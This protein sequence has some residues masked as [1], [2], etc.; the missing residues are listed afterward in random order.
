M[1]NDKMIRFLKS[2]KIE[3]I[4]DF[5]LDFEMIGRNR[6]NKDQF[7]MIILKKTPWKFYLLE[8][9]IEALKNIDYKYTIQFSYLS[10]PSNDDLI[11]L[12]TDWYKSIY[13][14]TSPFEIEIQDNRIIASIREN[15]EEKSSLYKPIIDDFNKFLNF[16]GYEFVMN[17]IILPPLPNSGMSKKEIKQINKVAKTLANEEIKE[18]INSNSGQIYTKDTIEEINKNHQIDMDGTQNVLLENM[19][20]NFEDMKKERERIRLNKRGNYIPF[21]SIDLIDSNSGNVDFDGKIFSIDINDKGKNKRLTIG[22]N[23][24]FGGAIYV[25]MYENKQVND[26]FI[27]NLAKGANIRVRGVAYIDDFSKALTIKGHY[28]DLLPADVINHETSPIPRVELHLHSQMS[29]QDG[30]GSMHDYMELAQKLGHKAMA[31]TDHGVVQGFPEAYKEGKAHGIKVIYGCEFYMVD[32]QLSYV[33]NPTDI[34]LNKANYVVLDLETTGLSC[35]YNRMMEFGAVKVEKGIVTQR[36]DLLINPG[37]EIP[38]KISEITNITNEMLKDKPLAKDALKQIL[39]FIGDSIIVTH[40]ASFDYNFLNEELK[41]NGMEVI[42]NPVIDTLSLSRYLF[43]ENRR[44]SLGNL[45]RTMEVSYDEESAHRADYDAE[46][47]NEVWQPMLSL[48]TKEN[49]HLKHSDLANLK[50]P[51]ELL[52]HIMPV[53]IVALAKNKEGIKSLYKLVSIGH[54][55]YLAGLPKVPRFELEKNRENLIIGSAC[56]NGEVFRSARYDTEEEIKRKISFYDYIEIQPLENYSFLVN[57][58]ELSDSE[59]KLCV[60]DIIRLAKEMNKPVVATGDAHYV[61]KEDKQFRDVYI[62]SLQVGGVIHPLNP[63]SRSK[64]PKFENPDQHYR[65]TDEM[66]E[67]FSFLSNELAYEIVVTNSNMISDMI[68]ADLE[69]IP[70]DKLYTP[71]IDNCENMLSDLCYQNAYKLYGNPLPDFIEKRLKTELNGIISNGFS[72]IYWIAHCLVKK[73]NDD[74]FL[75]GS[76]G[77]VGSSFVA[78]MANITEVN[79]LPPHYRCPKCRHLEWTSTTYPEIKSGYDLPKK[80]CPICGEEMVCDGQN[81]PFETFLGFKAEK[82]PDIDLNFPGDYQ[83][84]AHEYTKVLLGADNVFRAG[85]IETV[86]EKTAFGFAK[87]YLERMGYD[88]NKISKAKISYLASGCVD[89]KRT[90]GQHPGGIVVIPKDHSVYDFTAIQYPADEKD[91]AWKTTHFD[92]HSLHDTILKLD[93]L[94][95]VDPLALKMMCT[96]TNINIKDIPLNDSEVIKLFSSIEPLHMKHNYLAQKTGALAIPEFGTEFVRG[97]LESTKP[98]TI[99]ELIIISGL[100]H[101]T[102]VWNGN[103]EKL[104]K[105]GV[106]TL[107]E[108]IGC[109]DDIMT[110]LISKGLPSSV[111]FKIMEDVRKGKGLK[112]EYEEAMIANNVPSYYINSCKLIKYLFPKGHATAYVM[113]ALRVGYFKIHYPLE[114][115]A[116]FFSVRSKQYD[117][118]PMIKGESAIVERLEQLKMKDRSKLEKLTPK[119]E[120]QLKTLQICVEMVQRGFKFHNIDLYKSDATNFVVDHKNNALYPPFI[121]LDGLGESAA[122][123]I[124]EARKESEFYS[125]EDLL[126]RTKLSTTN[127]KDLENLGVLKGLPDNDQLSLFDF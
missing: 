3:N 118:V 64:L 6:F 34:E 68:E 21:D 119:E 12:F 115:Y 2:I 100:S 76:R 70:L 113:M 26:E 59:L 58:N 56:F 88:I 49:R 72:V 90:T 47:L 45:C 10:F 41:R 16:I 81:I 4:D 29:V 69:P 123:S 53:H 44:H 51:I 82:V 85:T 20:R 67:C 102:N 125:K 77:S 13:H 11:E 52:K 18:E 78:T 114:F 89:V 57:M 27:N 87:G 25:N 116:T 62:N 101:G 30:V 37:V 86:A 98:T 73:A 9:F 46:V 95:H 40:N 23:D 105:D 42:K 84:K 19:K 38:K 126:R 43:P 121:T 103:A 104:I 94:G 71:K 122:I 83:A 112:P 120:E 124:I 108:V 117:I 63:Y 110:F 35:R 48:L 96:L 32:D 55:D 127:L 65:S 17:L 111:S 74:G 33:F 79:P 14:S 60:L 28:L 31:I 5:D 22:V 97:I 106:A 7:D 39:N 109:R 24:K 99:N 15:E 92:F 93:L 80:K 1:S 75:V 91:S 107:Q 8:K 61:K 54:I 66:L 36:L 50:T